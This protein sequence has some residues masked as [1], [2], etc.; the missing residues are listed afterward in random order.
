MCSAKL[1]IRDGD[2]SGQVVASSQRERWGELRPRE[3]ALLGMHR[4][5]YPPGEAHEPC[6]IGPY[7]RLRRTIHLQPHSCPFR[8]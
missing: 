8:P 6:G 2:D 7:D 4:L 3:V 5:E 1:R